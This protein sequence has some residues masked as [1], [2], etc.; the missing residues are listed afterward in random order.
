MSILIL[1]FLEKALNDEL[2]LSINNQVIDLMS[3]V[4]KKRKIFK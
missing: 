3:L 1:I 2:S 4:K